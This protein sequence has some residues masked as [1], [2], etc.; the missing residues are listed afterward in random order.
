MARLPVA[1]GTTD[2]HSVL[3]YLRTNKRTPDETLAGIETFN[4]SGVIAVDRVGKCSITLEDPRDSRGITTWP[5]SFGE[6]AGMIEHC[7]NALSD[8]GDVDGDEEN[9]VG[10]VAG[11][12]QQLSERLN[13]VLVNA[14]LKTS[15]EHEVVTS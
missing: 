2:A 3:N 8:V 14:A 6:L 1:L 4:V 5:N 15:L 11:E 12:L 7:G 13:H 9:E 10:D